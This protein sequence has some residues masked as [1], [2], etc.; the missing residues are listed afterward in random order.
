MVSPEEKIKDKEEKS[1]DKENDAGGIL[2]KLYL[3]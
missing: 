3:L 1:K 2:L